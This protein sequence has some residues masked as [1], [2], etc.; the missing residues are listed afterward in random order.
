MGDM[1]AA[2]NNKKT[3]LGAALAVVAQALAAGGYLSPELLVGVQ[4]IAAG[5]MA[6]GLFHKGYRAVQGE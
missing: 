2:T 1:I 5:V 3:N 6:L 4:Q